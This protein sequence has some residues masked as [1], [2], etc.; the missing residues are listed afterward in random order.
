MNTQDSVLGLFLWAV[1]G[2]DCH[3]E[4]AKDT[5]DVQEISTVQT[6]GSTGSRN[7]VERVGA[8]G[9]DA[10]HRVSDRDGSHEVG[11]SPARGVRLVRTAS[12][13]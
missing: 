7:R 13:L 12:D 2:S 5:G 1:A 9:M 4:G 10:A 6:T 11:V 8:Y 3:S